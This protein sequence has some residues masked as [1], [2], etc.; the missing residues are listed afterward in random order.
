MRCCVAMVTWSDETLCVVGLWRRWT[1][2]ATAG[3]TG[4][5]LAPH[6]TRSSCCS[7][8]NTSCF[9]P[10]PGPAVRHAP[11]LF[12]FWKTHPLPPFIR[13]DTP[14]FPISPGMTCPLFIFNCGRHT[15]FP[16]SFGKTHP[17]FQF[18]LGRH[19]PFSY[20]ILEEILDDVRLGKILFKITDW[21]IF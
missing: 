2:W 13:E 17:F 5:P 15:P 16:L 3:P 9:L 10:R 1:A 14:P 8:G 19:A 20:F 12:P 7:P 21:Y 11:S 4:L 6:P 18:H